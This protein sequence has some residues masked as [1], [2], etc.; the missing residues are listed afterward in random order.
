MKVIGYG[1]ISKAESRGAASVS[2][3]VQHRECQRYAESQGWDFTFLADEGVSGGIA[4]ED[5]PRF[6]AALALL[7]A[8]EAGALIVKRIDRAS[9]RTADFANL[10]HLAEQQGWQVI[11]TELG[12]DTRTPMGKAMAN[13]AVTFAELERDFI[14]QRTREALAVKKNQGVTLGRPRTVPEDIA[15]R[16]VRE[17]NEDKTAYA[18]ARDLNRDEVP[19]AHGGKR[20]SPQTVNRILA[21][22][23]AE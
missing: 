12:I 14:R 20:W 18:I 6:K 1:R 23:G 15:C 21:R 22:E 13:I 17:F 19:T 3:E 16:I 2:I 11:V 7:A 8:G 9:R 10:L 5:R 4:P